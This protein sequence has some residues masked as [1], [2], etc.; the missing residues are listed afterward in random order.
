MIELKKFMKKDMHRAR[1]G[2]SLIELLVVM[3]IIILLTSL[4]SISLSNARAISRDAKRVTDIRQVQLALELYYDSVGSYPIAA[5]WYG[6]AP[7]NCWPGLVTDDWVPGLAPKYIPVLPLDP[8]PTLCGSV[9]FYA[10]DGANYKVIAHHPED[11]ENAKTK[12]IIDPARDGG[13]NPAIVDG[14]ACWA[15]SVYTRGAATW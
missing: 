15:W 2:F 3:S 7:G 9:Y 13:P 10:S 1:S 5:R 12:G 8:M 11:C 6:G 4:V 14:N